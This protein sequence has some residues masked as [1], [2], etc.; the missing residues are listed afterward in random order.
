MRAAVNVQAPSH[1]MRTAVLA[2]WLGS[3]NLGDRIIQDAIIRKLH[4]YGVAPSLELGVHCRPTLRQLYSVRKYKAVLFGGTNALGNSF[5]GRSG[6][7]PD[8]MMFYR[9]RVVLMGV[10]WASYA[11]KPTGLSRWTWSTLLSPDAIHAVRDQHTAEI[12][13]SMN[14]SAVMTGCPT[15]WNLSHPR[16]L[17]VGVHTSPTAILTVTNYSRDFKRDN[18]WIAIV[19]RYFDSVLFQPMAAEDNDYLVDGL[20]IERARILPLSLDSLGEAVTQP[21]KVYIGTRLHA[22][23]RALQLGCPTLILAIDNRATEMAKSGCLPIVD[24]HDGDVIESQVAAMR[25]GKPLP[26]TYTLPVSQR[27]AVKR[28]MEGTVRLLGCG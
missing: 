4:A 28:F 16:Q 1:L 7:A 20:G 17:D 3:D 27:I 8:L 15:T 14:F 26:A 19:Q 2:P 21:D 24:V 11:L 22:G 10:G 9:R 23:V 12:L 5:R 6:L 18:R 13:E 25:C